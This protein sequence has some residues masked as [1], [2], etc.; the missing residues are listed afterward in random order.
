MVRRVCRQTQVRERLLKPLYR[1][2]TAPASIT[3]TRFLA[4][5]DYVIVECHGNATTLAGQLYANTYCF[6]IR[7]AEGTLREMTEYTDTALVERALGPPD[8]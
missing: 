1:Q 4:E 2:F 6:V 3:A 7:M 8:R 5:G